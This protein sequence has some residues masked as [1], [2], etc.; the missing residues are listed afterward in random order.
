MRYQPIEDHGI[1][2]NM[3]S[4]AFNFDWALAGRAD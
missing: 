1:V 4:A 2:E 3:P